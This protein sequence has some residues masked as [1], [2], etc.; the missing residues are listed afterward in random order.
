MEKDYGSIVN[1]SKMLVSA[2]ENAKEQEI[3]HLTNPRCKRAEFGGV[4]YPLG[5][6]AEREGMPMP[7]LE[8]AEMICRQAW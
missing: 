2:M 4:L 5:R 6:L 8:E 3:K 7:T 1:L